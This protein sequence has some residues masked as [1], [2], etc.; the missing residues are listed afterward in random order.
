MPG[1]RGLIQSGLRELLCHLVESLIERNGSRRQVRD[2]PVLMGLR[3][4]NEDVCADGYAKTAPEVSHQIDQCG[5]VIGFSVGKVGIGQ[6]IDRDEKERK[7]DCLE[8]AGQS[9]SLEGNYGLDGGK[10]I[11]RQ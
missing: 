4:A 3:V 9:K 7:A 1:R 2:K 5:G 11:E 8:N 6:G 10:M